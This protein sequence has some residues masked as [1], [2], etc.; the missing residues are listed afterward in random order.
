MDLTYNGSTLSIP[1]RQIQNHDSGLLLV[2]NKYL[3][4]TLTWNNAYIQNDLTLLQKLKTLEQRV[5]ANENIS[6]NVT[7]EDIL[8]VKKDNIPQ[9]FVECNAVSYNENG[10]AQLAYYG[11]RHNNTNH[12]STPMSY[13][14]SGSQYFDHLYSSDIFGKQDQMATSKGN[15]VFTYDITFQEPVII[16][17][18][19]FKTVNFDY[20]KY[21][22][23]KFEIFVDDILT[24]TLHNN[25]TNENVWLDE[26][27]FYNDI[28][29]TN[30][31]IVL[32]E[33]YNT[34]QALGQINLCEPGMELEDVFFRAPSISSPHDDY[35][36]VIRFPNV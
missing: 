35:V 29:T 16:N 36:Y 32:Y 3:D 26:L 22:P 15:S 25:N 4:N 31:K 28:K 6:Q 23:V 10:E 14:V 17:K 27:N 33:N 34:M 2:G 11:S 7:K 21:T 13:T 1:D 24:A 18:V 12:T 5:T 20:S 9:G 8:L 19:L 30:Y